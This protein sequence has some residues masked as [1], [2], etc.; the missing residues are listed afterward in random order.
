MR[1]Q[2]CGPQGDEGGKDR[3]LDDE[4]GWYGR[5]RHSLDC[6]H[7]GRGSRTEPKEG[8]GVECT[9]ENP[10]APLAATIVS[11]KIGID[12]ESTQ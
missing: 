3:A 12:T 9:N 10:E 11:F 2:E 4:S 5:L 8:C 6:K 1:G 7:R